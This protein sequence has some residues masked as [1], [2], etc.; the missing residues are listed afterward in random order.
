MEFLSHNDGGD[1]A[2]IQTFTVS[3]SIDTE[4][5]LIHDSANDATDDAFGRAKSTP[6]GVLK[7]ITIVIDDMDEDAF[8]QLEEAE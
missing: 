8:R 4:K 7:T 3:D 5:T 6:V 1:M 2:K